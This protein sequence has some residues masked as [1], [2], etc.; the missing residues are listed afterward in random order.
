MTMVPL[1]SLYASLFALIL[2][3]ITI[4]VGLRRAKTKIFAGDGGDEVLNRRIRAHANFL[5]YV[6]FGL[7][8]IALTEM[9]GAQSVFIHI[10][11]ATFLISRIMHYFTLIAH[12]VGITREISMLGTLAV[13]FLTGGWLLYATFAQ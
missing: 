11:G 4:R 2:I 8:L 12:P 1:S 10:V 5:E 13:F 7:L 9:I 3:P 6:P